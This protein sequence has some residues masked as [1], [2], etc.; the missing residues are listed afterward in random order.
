MLIPFEF[1][2]YA[3]LFLL[4]IVAPILEELIFR[5]ALWEAVSDYVK[6]EELQI[7]ISSLLF[8]LGHLVSMYLLP[9]DY[10]PFVL[11]QSVY[12]IILGFGVSQ[13]RIKTGSLTG[14]ILIHFLF[15]LGFYLGSLA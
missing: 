11:Y 2:S 14:S 12:V 13:M 4:L 10:R 1:N 6:S 7:W 5:F 9:P 15:N 3:T 8:A